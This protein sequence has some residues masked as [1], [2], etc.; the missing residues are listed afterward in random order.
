L[1]QTDLGDNVTVARTTVDSRSR[2][3]TDL[4]ESISHDLTPDGWRVGM[5]LSPS[6]SVGYFVIG[7]SLIGGTDGLYS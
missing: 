5:D 6:G 4:V 3:Y 2:T 7:S 1:L